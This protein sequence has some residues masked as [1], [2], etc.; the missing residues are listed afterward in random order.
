MNLDD[1]TKQLLYKIGCML[2]LSLLM[3]GLAFLI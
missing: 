2:L 3:L 1:E